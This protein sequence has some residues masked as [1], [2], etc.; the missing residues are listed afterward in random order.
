[1][2]IKPIII[3]FSCF[4][5]YFI[6]DDLCFNFLRN[7]L[8]QT[9]QNRGISHNI[10]YLVLGLPL[11]IGVLLIDKPVNF[12]KNLG[13][14]SSL[15]I[16]LIFS[17]ICTLPMFIGFAFLFPF[18][19]ELTMNEFLIAGI[20]AA[21]FEE[22]YFRG[23]LFGL[24]FKYSRLGFILSVISGAVLFAL[25]HL[26]QSQDLT[27]LIGIFLTTFI[28][29]II[30]SWVYVEWKFNLWVPI[31]L[32]FFMN[33]SW[34]L[35]SVSDNALGDL[36]ANIFRIITILLIFTITFIYKRRFKIPFCIT[37]KSIWIISDKLK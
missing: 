28:G 30:F 2:K 6:L 8:D 1:M 37:K 21:L 24:P 23:F 20:A 35:F 11:F 16:G 12:L 7:I 34:M 33:V 19:S 25:I 31:G 22:L 27:T 5:I 15:F 18:N 29:A 26:Y 10:S 3:I 14:N 9:I 13:L 36:Y 17:I 4:C 32:H